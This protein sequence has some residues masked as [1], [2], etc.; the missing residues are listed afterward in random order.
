MAI[1]CD[2]STDGLSNTSPGITGAELYSWAVWLYRT[3]TPTV[4]GA[5]YSLNTNDEANNFNIDAVLV[6]GSNQLLSYVGDGVDSG[7]SG[8]GTTLAANTWYYV[9]GIN[10]SLATN[11]F[12]IYLNGVLDTQNAYV[13]TGRTAAFTREEMANNYTSNNYAFTGRYF[14]FMRWNRVLTASEIA[15]QM[16]RFE[17]IYPGD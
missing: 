1:L 3:A 2:A 10:S 15:Y 7:F 16:K 17:P 8:N 9:A 11:G 6:N 13:R 12:K 14:N 5:V 4:Y